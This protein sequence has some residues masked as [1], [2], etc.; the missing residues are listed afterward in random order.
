MMMMLMT[1]KDDGDYSNDANLTTD[2][3]RLRNDER[4]GKDIRPTM[5]YT[6]MLRPKGVPFSGCRPGKLVYI[7][8]AQEVLFQGKYVKG[9]HL[10][11]GI[12]VCNRSEYPLPA[13]KYFQC[14][15]ES[16]SYTPTLHIKNQISSPSPQKI[17]A[18]RNEFIYD[19][20]RN[21][22][23]FSKVQEFISCNVA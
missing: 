1:C 16:A 9:S 21:E 11:R 14:V 6:E 15:D 5:E 7:W 20:T 13:G 4:D 18:Y 3:W 10:R 23:G 12:R 22:R 2:I 17:A 8:Y 19:D